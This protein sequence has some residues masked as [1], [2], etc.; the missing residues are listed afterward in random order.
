MPTGANTRQVDLA[1]GANK[2]RRL[3][4]PSEPRSL[5]GSTWPP[6]PTCGQVDLATV[7]NMSGGLTLA[8]EPIQVDLAARVDKS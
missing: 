4:K 2:S 3:S 5:D 1:A 6:E 7:A 8:L